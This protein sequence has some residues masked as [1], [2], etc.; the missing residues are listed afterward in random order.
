MSIAVVGAGD[1]GRRY[2]NAV[3]AHAQLALVGVAEQDSSRRDDIT[4]SHGVPTAENL[5][6]LLDI[7]PDGVPDGVI[8]ATPPGAHLDDVRLLVER[9]VP[10][11]VEKPVVADAAGL[12]FMG[13][14]STEHRSLIVPAHISRHLDSVR[15]L[16]RMVDGQRLLLIN[17]WRYVP[18]ERLALHGGDHPALSAMIHDLDLVRCVTRANVDSLHVTSTR[19]EAALQYPDSV[20]ATMTMDNGA[21]VTVGNSWTLPNSSRYVEATFEVV[22]STSKY[23]VRT[24]SDALVVRGDHGDEYPAAELGLVG[25]G[26]LGGAFDR[27]LSYFAG[28]I[29]R[30]VPVEVDVSDAE[31]SIDVALKI[32]TW[33]A[34]S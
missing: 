2:V 16:R 4:D 23:V 19:S 12:E 21:L 3:S 28:I 29:T 33:G 15:F 34:G 18:R 32:A 6:Q 10:V 24:P 5:S 13:S 11:L 31:W 26:A 9:G 30:T 7:L 8:I 22:T 25:E 27:Q 20:V 1:F 17:A 14:L